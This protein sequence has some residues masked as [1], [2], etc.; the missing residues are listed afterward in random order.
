LK[1][2]VFHEPGRIAV[3]DRPEPEPGVGEVVVRTG[4]AAICYSD[5]RVYR[6]LKHAKPGVIPGHEIAGEVVALGEGVTAVKQGDRVAVCPIAACGS[7]DYCLSGRRHR[8]PLRATLG[9]DVDGG[10]AEYVLVPASIVSIGHLFPMP[11]GLAFDR[12]C[13]TEPLACVL[14]S[15]E[16][17][18]AGI[19]RSL[20]IIGAGPM[21]LLHVLLAKRMGMTPLIVSE[22]DE[23]RAEMARQLGATD[24]IDPRDTDLAAAAKERTDGLGAHAA[25]VTSGVAEVL[26]AALGSVRRQ[27]VVS[28]FA[29]FPPET[30]VPFDPNL[31]H[32]S[33]ARLTGSQNAAPEQYRRVLQLLPQLDEVD[34]ITT[35]RVPLANAT[36]A[37]EVRLR[38]E[39]LKSTVLM[40]G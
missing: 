10:I 26:D 31:V 15:L 4:A 36:E 2:L 34:S 38:N 13:L 39:G 1:A 17:G 32:Y 11:Y 8:C 23:E 9:Y 25:I 14:N 30:S 40:T 22:P 5:I 18:N 35:H 33:E 16:A 6:G 24:V 28:L 21:G 7:C 29:G 3:E 37:Y 27:G 12:G 20:V 19:G